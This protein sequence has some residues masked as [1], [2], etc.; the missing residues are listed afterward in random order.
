MTRPRL[1]TRVAGLLALLL[2]AL[3]PGGVPQAAAG[4]LGCRWA[5]ILWVEGP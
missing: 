4:G 2:V 1:R 5:G 3:G